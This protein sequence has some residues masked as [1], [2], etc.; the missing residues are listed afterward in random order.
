VIHAGR[1][2]DQSDLH[3][4]PYP[5]LTHDGRMQLALPPLRVA[6]VAG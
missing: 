2:A 4:D 1:A 5:I 6:A 3:L